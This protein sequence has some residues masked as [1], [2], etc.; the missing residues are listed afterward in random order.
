MNRAEIDALEYLEEFRVE[1]YALV[2]STGGRIPLYSLPLA[3]AIGAVVDLC[4]QQREQLKEAMTALE[5]NTVLL[6][7][8]LSE[9]DATPDV[10]TMPEMV[11]ENQRI[12][13]RWEAPQ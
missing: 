2:H 4:R 5:R 3:Q 1:G 13:S 8:L 11:K 10:P 7:A 6:Q 12:L 9:S